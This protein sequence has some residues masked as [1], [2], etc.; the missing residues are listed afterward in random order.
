MGNGHGD[1]AR[2]DLRKGTKKH[3][4][5]PALKAHPT[6]PTLSFLSISG[7]VVNQ[8]RGSGGGIRSI[9]YCDDGQQSAFAVCGLDR[10]LR[11]FAAEPPTLLHKVH[12][13]RG[14]FRSKKRKG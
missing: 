1:L 2:V 13:C 4:V 6:I 11:V 5:L 7:C 9:S 8:Y 3:Y 12:V 14:S 10:Y